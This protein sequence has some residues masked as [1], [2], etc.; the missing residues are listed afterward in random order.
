MCYNQDT[1]RISLRGGKHHTEVSMEE[2]KRPHLSLILSTVL[3]IAA[4]IGM[5]G[6][7]ILLP[8]IMTH[9][10]AHFVPAA[11]ERFWLIVAILYVAL[12]VALAVVVLLLRL[13]RVVWTG[14]VFTMVSSRLV[15]AIACL[16]VAEG[17]V[18]GILGMM[19]FPLAYAVCFV[20]VTMGLCLMV[21]R[22]V[23]KDAA[24]LKEENDGTI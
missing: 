19:Y 13:L 2:M 8:R 10:V 5:S 14:R 16:V 23:L 9:Y 6:A 15:M 17:L 21:V 12:A 4:L 3:C 22:T 7:A 1:S 24:A 11:M 18:F 20:A